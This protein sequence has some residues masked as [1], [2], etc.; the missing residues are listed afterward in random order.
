MPKSTTSNQLTSFSKQV[1][2][3]PTDGTACNDELLSSFAS[4][5][6]ITSN[7]G[8]HCFPKSKQ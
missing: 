4:Y 8:S 3:N 7:H 1:T 5:P 6:H 2:C